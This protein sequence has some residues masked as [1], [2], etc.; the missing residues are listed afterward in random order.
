MVAANHALDRTPGIERRYVA[1]FSAG[2]G[3]GNR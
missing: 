3:H 1:N 2:A